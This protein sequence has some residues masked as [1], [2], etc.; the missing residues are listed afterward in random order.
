MQDE[1]ILKRVRSFELI[2]QHVSEIP[3]EV[4]QI[5]VETCPIPTLV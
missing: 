2:F 1:G 3:K 4:G 5:F